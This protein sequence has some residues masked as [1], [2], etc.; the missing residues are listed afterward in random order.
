MSAVEHKGT[1][2]TERIVHQ[3][4]AEPD[5]EDLRML[6]DELL[7]ADKHDALGVGI[8]TAAAG[9]GSIALAFAILGEQAVFDLVWDPDAAEG[10]E[11][12][13]LPLLGLAGF[14]LLVYLSFQALVNHTHTSD[15]L[16]RWR[17]K[18]RRLWSKFPLSSRT[19]RLRETIDVP[20]DVTW[21]TDGDG[22]TLRWVV[23]EG[24]AV[25][26][27][28][29]PVPRSELDTL[30][31]LTDAQLHDLQPTG[32]LRIDSTHRVR[33][34]LTRHPWHETTHLHIAAIGG[35]ARGPSLTLELAE[36]DGIT[37]AE[38]ARLD[39]M[40]R[41]G[42]RL[43]PGAARALVQTLEPIAEAVGAPV[44]QAVRSR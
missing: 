4:V 40:V 33:L 20:V 7:A 26:R 2:R 17:W 37:P 18:A 43:P 1:L 13:I 14:M 42:V 3:S 30:D 41:R 27:D 34:E 6:S 5:A 11:F 8:A 38:R 28:R 16:L 23:D 25:V 12:G 10:E 15:R 44:P 39:A 29:T 36:T 19:D 21:E 35:S 22:L 31:S 9:V 24:G 32:E